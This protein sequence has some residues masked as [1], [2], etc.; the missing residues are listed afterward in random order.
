MSALEIALR[1]LSTVICFSCFVTHCYS[2]R[3]VSLRLAQARDE[4]QQW[5]IDNPRPGP[6][7]PKE[8]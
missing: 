5:L 2:H 4:Q 1:Y 3:A 7:R 8:I 6:Y